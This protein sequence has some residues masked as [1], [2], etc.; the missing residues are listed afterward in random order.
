MAPLS[1]QETI[2]ELTHFGIRGKFVYLIEVIPLIEIIWADGKAQSGE[3]A[4]L[5]E[6]LE[7]LVRRVNAAAGQDLFTVDEARTFAH[8]FLTTRPDPELL[9]SLRT[10]AIAISTTSAARQDTK[11]SILEACIDIGASSVNSYP[12]DLKGR[13][14]DREKKCFFEILSSWPD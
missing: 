4:V 3:I 6:F 10:L 12:Y 2:Q 7:T 9:K 8:K 11:T 13:F 14:D 1:R 5:E